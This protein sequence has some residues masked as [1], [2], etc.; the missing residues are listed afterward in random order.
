[1][2]RLLLGMLLLRLLLGMLL[3]L[4]LRMLLLHTRP[5]HPALDLACHLLHLVLVSEPPQPLDAHPM[6]V[7]T[8]P[9][10]SL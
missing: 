8:L 4:L 1:M 9:I 2:L 3:L 10:S 5:I 7:V 6:D